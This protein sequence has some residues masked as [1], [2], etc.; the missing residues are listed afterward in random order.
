MTIQIFQLDYESVG[1]DRGG[2]LY[3]IGRQDYERTAGCF[4]PIEM[5]V[6][7]YNGNVLPCCHFVGDAEQHQN[8]VVGE[9]GAGRSLFEI[10]ASP[11]FLAWRKSLFTIGPKGKE[12]QK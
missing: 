2:I 8:L 11:A 12:C 10:Y 5:M 7:S 3:G 4:V 1:H 9:L 6:I